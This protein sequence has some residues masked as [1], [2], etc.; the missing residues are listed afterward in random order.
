[1]KLSSPCLAV[2]EAQM[3]IS[4]DSQGFHRTQSLGSAVCERT[5]KATRSRDFEL[6]EC[7]WRR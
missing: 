2:N 7:F 4:N 1:M 5:A 3:L 6:P